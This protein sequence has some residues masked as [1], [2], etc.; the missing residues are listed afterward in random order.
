MFD[1]FS[2]EG[3]VPRMS[4]GE[5]TPF[6]IYVNVTANLG[7]FLAY[8]L[9]P[10]FLVRVWRARKD[11]VP[12]ASSMLVW[13]AAFILLCGLTHLLQAL[14]FFWPAYRFFTAVDAV[15]AVVS[16]VTLFQLPQAVRY[17]LRFP[18]PRQ[19]QQ[20]ISDLRAVAAEKELVY[21]NLEI[22]N[23]V[24]KREAADLKELIGGLEFRKDCEYVIQDL[25]DQLARIE[26][27]PTEKARP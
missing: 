13:F 18:S 16:L 4:C 5:W 8:W 24:L 9:I 3:F 6:L 15:G 12:E 26:L 1:F 10:F 7:F 27:P 21:R 2:S 17:I 11:D 20:V 22:L 14:T 23:G 25:R 19:F